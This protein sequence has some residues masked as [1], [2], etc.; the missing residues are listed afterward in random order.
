MKLLILIITDNQP[1]SLCHNLFSFSVFPLVLLYVRTAAEEVFDALMLNAPTLS[2]L[3]EAVSVTRWTQKIIPDFSDPNSTHT[4]SLCSHSVNFTI[5]SS[6]KC[7]NCL[8]AGVGANCHLMFLSFP[9][10][11]F[12]KVRYAKRCHWE[13]LQKMQARVSHLVFSF[14]IIH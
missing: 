8:S 10:S 1:M 3:R 13:N 4:C 7:V 2:G 5:M 12:R 9:S 6:V 11:D 14:Y